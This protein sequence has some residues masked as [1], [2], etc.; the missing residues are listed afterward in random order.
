MAAINLLVFDEAHH[1]KK[2]APYAKIM[3]DFYKSQPVPEGLRKP[4]VFGMTASPFGANEDPIRASEGLENLLDCKIATYPLSEEYRNKAKDMVLYFQTLRGEFKT[5]LF[6]KL[7]GEI[8]NIEAFKHL[9]ETAKYLSSHLG[10]WAAEKFWAYALREE[11]KRK[12]QS[13]IEKAHGRHNKRKLD[14]I[15]AEISQLQSAYKLV[16]NYDF[17]KPRIDLD[18]ISSKVFELH[19]FL[20]EHYNDDLQNRCIVFVER[21]ATARMLKEIFHEIGATYLKPD[22]LTGYAAKSGDANISFRQQVLTMSQFRK[23]EINC[24]FATSVAE[25]GLDVPECNLVIRFDPYDTVIQYIQSKG[26]ARHKNSKF[27]DMIEQGNMRTL[28]KRND[29]RYGE[30]RLRQWIENLDPERKLSGN[31]EYENTQIGRVFTHPETNAK[32]TYWSALGVLS[33]FASTLVSYL[34]HLDF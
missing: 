27:V 2:G 13:K 12:A 18:S 5:P 15:D 30:R 7:D 3:E 34:H 25:E 17:G 33:L 11:E 22:I 10:R 19:R 24:L 31:D 14:M 4:R 6:Q 1:A 21:K 16:Q 32:L 9:F 20:C 29:A 23:G 8:G 28:T 26:R